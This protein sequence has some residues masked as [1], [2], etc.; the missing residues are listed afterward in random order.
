MREKTLFGRGLVSLVLSGMALC[1]A[2]AHAATWPAKPI[3][4]VVPAAPGGSADPLARLVAE[5]LGATL[6]QSIVVEN[7][8]GANGNIAVN[9]V[10]RESPDGHTLLFGWTGTLVPA[11][12]MYN[13]EPYHP[14]RD[15]D[16]IVLIGSVPN[17]IVV[18][19][20]L[21][22]KTF[23][24]LA[25]AARKQPG[26]LNFGS[27]G[28][29]SSYHLSGE[30]YKKVLGVSMTHVPYSSP[31]A[32]FADLLGGRLQLAFPGVTAAAPFVK[33]G[34]LNAVAVMA[35]ERSSVLPDVPTTTEAGQ[36]DLKS[37]TWFALLSP[38]NTPDEIR[39]RINEAVNAALKKTA[40]RDKLVELGF[41]PLGGSDADL[42]R[43]L[44]DDIRKWG[45][46]VRFS[47]AKVD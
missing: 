24:E 46:I 36:P 27:T 32:V 33:D 21:G 14:Q 23:P 34:R 26:K 16:P 40:F 25:E 18:Q 15:L 43:T 3:R 5:E 8:P 9:S 22:V 4:I 1:G 19:P 30:L 20:S 35:D 11:V 42:A 28:S 6:G 45:E 29:G 7:K 12:T 17:V 37:E 41:T 2:G 47:G 31:G 44:D 39:D 13:A 10:V 38:R